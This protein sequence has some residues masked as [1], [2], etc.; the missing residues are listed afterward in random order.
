MYKSRIRIS[1]TSTKFWITYLTGDFTSFILLVREIYS[2]MLSKY[3]SFQNESWLVEDGV[4]GGLDLLYYMYI[5][6]S[7]FV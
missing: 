5:C 6:G 3:H 2:T 1:I 7:N 4:Y